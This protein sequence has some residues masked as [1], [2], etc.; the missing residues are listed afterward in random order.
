VLAKAHQPV[1]GGFFGIA[2]QAVVKQVLGG[3]GAHGV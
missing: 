3:V 2:V 1:F